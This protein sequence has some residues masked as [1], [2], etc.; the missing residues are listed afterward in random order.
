MVQ[1]YPWWHTSLLFR[2]LFLL[3]LFDWLGSK[4]QLTNRL[5]LFP[6]QWISHTGPHPLFTETVLSLFPCQW[7][8]HAGPRPFS[9][10]TVLL[11]FPC[12][13]TPHT[14]PHSFLR[15]FGFFSFF[16]F[17]SVVSKEWFYCSKCA[18]AA[19][20]VHR[21]MLSAGVWLEMPT[22]RDTS[23]KSEDQHFVRGPRL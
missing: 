17:F 5:L 2:P 20:A 15:P 12:Q 19:V 16:F 6:C 7:T 13:W 18:T 4:H 23:A 9:T 10:E 1:W 22:R 21:S 3:K 11:L 14:G 8:L